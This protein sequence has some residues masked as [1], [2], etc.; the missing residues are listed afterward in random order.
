MAVGCNLLERDVRETLAVA[1][2]EALQVRAAL[3][4]GLNAS[5]CH[6]LQGGWKVEGGGRDG[7]GGWKVEGGGEVREGWAG[8]VE[9]GGWR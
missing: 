6:P 7:Q 2:T 5:I 8:W 1:D 9:G 4:E 3:T